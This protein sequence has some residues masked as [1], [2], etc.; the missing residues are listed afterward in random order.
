MALY[1]SRAPVPW[2]RDEFAA[3]MPEGALPFH[4]QTSSAAVA[5]VVVPVGA[6][7]H[8]GVYAYRVALL[9][10]FVGWEPAALEQ[11]EALE[12]LRALVNGTRI[13]VADAIAPVPPGVDTAAD[14]E[15]VRAIIEGAP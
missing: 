10:D 1:F 6:R 13:H 11:Y 14:L 15:A 7:R 3:S 5:P 4:G 2:S 12:Q 9:R 8:L